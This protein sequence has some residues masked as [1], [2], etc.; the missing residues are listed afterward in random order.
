MLNSESLPMLEAI[1]L[2]FFNG[3]PQTTIICISVLQDDYESWLSFFL[4]DT[5]M[6]PN[7]M[8]SRLN[9]NCAPIVI[10]KPISSISPCEQILVEVKES[11]GKQWSCP[12][13]HT[14]VD[15]IAPLFRTI[16]D[17]LIHIL[18][19]EASDNKIS[20]QART[21]DC[22][23]EGPWKDLL[24]GVSNSEQIDSSEQKKLKEDLEF[25]CKMDLH[26][27]LIKAISRGVRET[28]DVDKEPVILVM[29]LDIQSL[30]VLRKDEVYRMPSVMS[31]VHTCEKFHHSE[32]KSQE[33][34]SSFPV[35]NP[36]NVYY[37]LNPTGD[38]KLTHLNT[39]AT[40]IKEQF[41][42][43]RIV[44]AS[45]S[46]EKL[47]EILRSR[48][49]DLFIYTGDFKGGEYFYEGAISELER[50]AAIVELYF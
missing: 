4:P 28:K 31:I 33:N 42:R 8:F 3:L 38:D 44:G 26:E 32:K 48:D 7:I 47:E 11:S 37:V 9:S 21:V 40:W 41:K 14:S 36:F 30:P 13:G 5:P 25:I 27:D 16:L 6:R 17:H 1:I 43:P 24:F 19:E 49:R 29:D 10:V 35:I 50:C 39:L 46:Q 12:W 22:R 34:H 23:L 20:Q 45:P 18:D 2:I 15:R